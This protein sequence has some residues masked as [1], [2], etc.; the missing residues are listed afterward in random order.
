MHVVTHEMYFVY[1]IMK[2]GV[3]YQS[4]WYSYN[5]E[6]S[7][8]TKQFDEILRHFPE[9]NIRIAEHN[10]KTYLIEVGFI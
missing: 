1:I 5:E 10:A 9:S 2:R 8:D 4:T 7:K 3:F 6:V